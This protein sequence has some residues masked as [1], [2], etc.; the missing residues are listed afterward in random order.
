M[1]QL[2]LRLRHR[3]AGA[4]QRLQNRLTEWT[5][6]NRGSIVMGMYTGNLDVPGDVLADVPN[7]AP[8]A[9]KLS[10]TELAGKAADLAGQV[11]GGSGSLK[12]APVERSHC[13]V[14]LMRLD[15]GT[16]EIQRW[17]LGGGLVRAEKEEQP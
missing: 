10:C 7:T 16:G 9:A 17:N 15:E 11:H 3:F 2:G 6:I 12:E 8:S 13:D 1:D 4:E 14:R 5:G